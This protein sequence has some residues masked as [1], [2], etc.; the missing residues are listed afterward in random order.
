MIA[1]LILGIIQTA[2]DALQ[3][4]QRLVGRF[5]PAVATPTPDR[6]FGIGEDP[7]EGEREKHAE[8]D[9]RGLKESLEYLGLK[10]EP[11][12]TY[13]EPAVRAEAGWKRADEQVSR[14]DRARTILIAAIDTVSLNMEREAGAREQLSRQVEIVVRKLTSA[15]TRLKMPGVAEELGEVVAPLYVMLAKPVDVDGDV[16]RARKWCINIRDKAWDRCPKC[17]H[18]LLDHLQ[19]G[20]CQ[21]PAAIAAEVF[22]D[23]T[24]GKPVYDCDCKEMGCGDGPVPSPTVKTY[25]RRRKRPD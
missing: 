3:R 8:S 11:G 14:L 2:A 16:P 20:G 6:P 19:M 7:L 18:Y 17:K 4:A 15:A 12:T 24:S 23:P 9:L 1:N 13:N 21:H 25:N 22:V 5:T 10:Y